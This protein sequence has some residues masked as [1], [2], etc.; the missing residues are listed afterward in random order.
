M[1]PTIDMFVGILKDYLPSPLIVECYNSILENDVAHNVDHIYAVVNHGFEL[2]HRTD[3][4]YKLS[5]AEKAMVLAGCLMHDLG[6]RYD[7]ET[8]HQIAYGMSYRLLDQFAPEMFSPEQKKIIALSCLEHRAS[9]RGGCSNLISVLVALADR[10]KPDMDN[11]IKRSLLFRMDKPYDTDIE[12]IQYVYDHLKEK[13][14]SGGYM[15]K[16]YPEIGWLIYP[17]EI[18]RIQK[19]VDDDEALHHR[20]IEVLNRLHEKPID[21]KDFCA[22]TVLEVNNL[23][24]IYPGVLLVGTDIKTGELVR[25]ISKIKQTLVRE[26]QTML[27]TLEDDT[28]FVVFN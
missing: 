24:D 8:H 4:K 14:A 19:L 28:G 2:A 7:R 12:L 13:I 10:G 26:D 5:H 23:A 17:D 6:C 21:P 22:S 15:W 20:I 3:R 27:V 25:S 9:W 11:Y 16:S 1:K 18:D